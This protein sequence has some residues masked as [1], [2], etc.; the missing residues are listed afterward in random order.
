MNIASC[1]IGS[2]GLV[3]SNILSQ[4]HFSN[5]VHSTDAMS[6]RGANIVEMVCAGARGT[7]WI[8]NAKPAEDLGDLM[9][10]LELLETVKVEKFTLISTID[11]YARIGDGLDESDDPTVPPEHAYGA[12]RLMF[13]KE[14]ARLFPQAQILRL[15][16]V[17]GVGLKKNAFFD[18]LANH[19]IEKLDSQ[20]CFQ[21]YD[22]G[23]LASH[24]GVARRLN[25]PRVNLVTEPLSMQEL[26]QGVFSDRYQCEGATV[27]RKGKCP[28]A[29]QRIF[30]NYNVCTRNSV[31]EQKEGPKNY[32][33]SKATVL[34]SMSSFRTYFAGGNSCVS[35]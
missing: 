6:I 17:Y 11:V 23:N 2:T 4:R 29:S 16:G 31:S 7:K 35:Q 10:L 25:Q 5:A 13:E 34:R 15:P 14:V 26:V 24:I 33:A 3:G 8:A 22:L 27:Y 9:K 12:H 32:I 28:V 18:L 20:A 1:L 30:A 21:W 19:E